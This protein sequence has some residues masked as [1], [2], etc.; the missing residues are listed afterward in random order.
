VQP[1]ATGQPQPNVNVSAGEPALMDDARLQI[2]SERCGSALTK[3]QF[4]KFHPVEQPNTWD[5]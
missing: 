5:C 1:G 4:H 2:V 3:E